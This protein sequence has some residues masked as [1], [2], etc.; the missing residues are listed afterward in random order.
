MIE[1]TTGNTTTVEF[2]GTYDGG[3]GFACEIGR[4]TLG[5]DD[6]DAAAVQALRL[7]ALWR[8]APGTREASG[9]R[10]LLAV[11]DKLA[12]C[13][14]SEQADLTRLMTLALV[15]YLEARIDATRGGARGQ[16]EEPA[17]WQ[18][19]LTLV[20]HAGSIAPTN[21][22]RRVQ[23]IVWEHLEALRARHVALPKLL[24]VLADRLE[25]VKRE[26]A[27]GPAD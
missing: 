4:R 17:D 8:M 18:L 16:N 3:A 21:D 20:D 1:R 15:T 24:R 23:E 19:A 13:T 7:G 26:V 6:L 10:A 11:A 27:E 22:W 2:S 25:L 12:P 5:L 14:T 9:C